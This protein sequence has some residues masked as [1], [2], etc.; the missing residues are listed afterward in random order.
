MTIEMSPIGYAHT[1]AAEIPRHWTVSDVEGTLVVDGRYVEGCKDIEA[2]RRIVVLFHFDRSPAFNEG[3]LSQVPPNRTDKLGVFSICSPVRPNPIGLS[4]L[5]VLEVRGTTIR[6]RGVDMLDG[7]PIL[8]IKPL[9][10]DK[11]TC[12]A[13]QGDR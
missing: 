9:V 8:D 3:H 7:T 4:V 11:A 5:E 12:P 10:L 6:V 1:D 13:F 2:G